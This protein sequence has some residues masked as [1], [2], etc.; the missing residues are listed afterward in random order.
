MSDDVFVSNLAKALRKVGTIHSIGEEWCSYI[1]K[2]PTGGV[3]YCG[4]EVTRSTYSALW[5]WAN[6]QGLVKSESAWQAIASAQNG[7]VPFYSSGNG[8]TTFRMPRL[9]GYVKGAASQSD[10]GKHI[11]EG[12]PNATG[13]YK[14]DTDPSC[15]PWETAS[16]SGMAYLYG[17]IASRRGMA[18]SGEAYSTYDA[19]GF[20]LSRSNPIYGNSDHVTPDTSTVLFGVYAY[21]ALTNTD[22]M[23]VNA[24]ASALSSLEANVE[25]RL[26][27]K[28]GS[29]DAPVIT[30]WATPD[31]SAGV[32]QTGGSFT[33]PC[34]GLV[35]VDLNWATAS[36]K[37]TVNGVVF[38]AQSNAS[39]AGQWSA[40][41]VIVSKGDVVA[42]SSSSS[43]LIF[44]PFKGAM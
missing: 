27:E 15:G 2:I 5:S 1:G 32:S 44:Y 41:C 13:I 19:I 16:A 28:L 8:S 39:S 43:D 36:R 35:I 24:I 18:N 37:A 23:D 38:V 25:A 30:D 42:L 29:S 22:S 31:Y 7:N 34:A 14:N 10:S 12:L 26:L 21:G 11:A 4:Q 3:P 33:A 6:A 9:V 40:G 20:D 17:S